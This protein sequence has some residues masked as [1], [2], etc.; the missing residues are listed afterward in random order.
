M[1]SK[2]LFLSF[3]L[4]AF[5]VTSGLAAAQ[6]TT[7][8][9]STAEPAEEISNLS[10]TSI[11]ITNDGPDCITIVWYESNGHK[12]HEYTIPADSEPHV[13]TPETVDPATNLPY[14]IEK[15]EIKICSGTM[16]DAKGTISF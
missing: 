16:K 10:S 13:L 14:P 4:L 2:W 6:T 11:T 8:D 1:H 9:V 5:L 15:V 3:L 12:S 7:W